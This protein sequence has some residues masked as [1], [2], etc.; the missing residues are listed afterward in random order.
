MMTKEKILSFI[1]KYKIIIILSVVVIILIVIKLITPENTQKT[2]LINQPTPTITQS[3]K[4]TASNITLE[5]LK[6]MDE[7]ELE[8]FL[9][10]LSEDELSQLPEED[11]TLPLDYLLPHEEENFKIIKYIKEGVLLVESKA[12]DKSKAKESLRKWLDQYEDTL[13]E[14]II[15]WQ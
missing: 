13:G 11:P 6:R 14:N 15:V 2:E 4:K 9:G 12:S 7:S 3:P 10:D 8:S 5:D 1:S